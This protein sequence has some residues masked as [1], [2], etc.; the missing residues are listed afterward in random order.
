MG[1]SE[2][3]RVYNWVLKWL[4][5][6]VCRYRDWRNR[7]GRNAKAV[8]VGG[9]DATNGD[10]GGS[11]TN[12]VAGGGGGAAGGGGGEYTTAQKKK[13]LRVRLRLTLLLRYYP[14][15]GYWLG[16]GVLTNCSGTTAARLLVDGPELS[17]PQRAGGIWPFIRSTTCFLQRVGTLDSI[18]FS[19]WSREKRQ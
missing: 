3:R 18:S 12:G 1:H 6:H 15:A 14:R 10:A 13:A 17:G 9:M 4:L 7:K 8:K 5:W 19:V 16:R 2:D 11:M